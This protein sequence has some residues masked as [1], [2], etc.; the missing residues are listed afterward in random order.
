MIVDRAIYRDGR[1]VAA[2]ELVL[3]RSLLFPADNDI[4]AALDAAAA[5]VAG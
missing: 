2:P 5:I 4:A 1:R 3:G